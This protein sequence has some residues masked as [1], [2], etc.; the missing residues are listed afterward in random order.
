MACACVRLR[1]K[2]Q[3]HVRMLHVPSLIEHLP[4]EEADAEAS[5]KLTTPTKPPATCRQHCWPK[6]VFNLGQQLPGRWL[7]LYVATVLARIVS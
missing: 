6:N 1:T 4:E 3:V 2:L 5:V 7:S